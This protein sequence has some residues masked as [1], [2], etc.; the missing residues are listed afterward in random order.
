MR[1]A[2]Y[3]LRTSTEVWNR[4]NSSLSEIAG[5][6]TLD[7]NNRSLPHLTRT[8]RAPPPTFGSMAQPGALHIGTG[9]WYCQH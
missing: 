8:G 9:G 1:A 7:P 2:V 4:D 3:P 5:K 6:G